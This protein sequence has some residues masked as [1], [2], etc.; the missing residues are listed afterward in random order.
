M[1]KSESNK[2]SFKRQRDCLARCRRG[3]ETFTE[4]ATGKRPS[5]PMLA[6][7]LPTTPAPVYEQ[8]AWSQS[9]GSPIKRGA[10]VLLYAPPPKLMAG[11]L[12]LSPSLTTQWD[13]CMCVFRYATW[14]DTVTEL[15]Q[16]MASPSPPSLCCSYG[17]WSKTQD[18]QIARKL[19][20]EANVSKAE[21]QTGLIIP[22]SC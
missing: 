11:Y 12:F 16:P 22:F 14:Y 21:I 1:D 18:D 9:H 5:E 7:E 19:K 15:N 8:S 3:K 4:A 2:G 6:Q 13:S 20:G 17:Y 10:K